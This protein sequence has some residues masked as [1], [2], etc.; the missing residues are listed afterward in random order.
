MPAASPIFNFTMAIKA[1]LNSRKSWTTAALL[2]LARF[3]RFRNCAYLLQGD[4][5]KA[6]TAYQDFFAV[7][8][9]AGSDILVLIAAKS[10]Y[11][12]LP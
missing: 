8:K 10:E 7:W 2:L 11:A 9:E 1:P 6:R 12:K 5:A 4:S 3:S